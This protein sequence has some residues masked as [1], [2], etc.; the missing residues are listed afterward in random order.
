[1]VLLRILLQRSGLKWYELLLLLILAAGVAY[2]LWLHHRLD[3]AQ[4]SLKE[5]EWQ[6]ETAKTNYRWLWDT[7]DLADNIVADYY[8]TRELKRQEAAQA[9][10]ELVRLY[11]ELVASQPPTDEHHHAH[12]TQSDHRQA[13]DPSVPVSPTTADRAGLELVVGRMFDT[14]CSATRTDPRC[15][16]G[17]P[18]H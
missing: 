14:Y 7:F 4:N 2:Y 3:S 13:A 10:E 18:A 12:N 1:M 15:G 9:R 8:R 16:T 6:L 11:Q 5:A 17:E